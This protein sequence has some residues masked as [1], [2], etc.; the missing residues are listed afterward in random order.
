[1]CDPLSCCARWPHSA[2]RYVRSS[3]SKLKSAI[4]SSRYLILVAW[5]P[6][7]GYN[8]SIVARCKVTTGW[9]QSSGS[10]L[11]PNPQA[12]SGSLAGQGLAH[13]GSSRRARPKEPGRA[14]N[15]LL[16]NKGNKLYCLLLLLQAAYA[17]GGRMSGAHYPDDSALSS[18][19]VILA[20][21]CLVPS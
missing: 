4:V 17:H 19:D 6:T 11:I 1:M 2:K 15:N 14:D 3:V 9:S 18:A 21:V 5:T 10:E 8:C 16:R 7:F 20:C 12:T 13:D